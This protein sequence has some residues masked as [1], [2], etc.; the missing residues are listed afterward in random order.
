[1]H[2]SAELT[3]FCTVAKFMFLESVWKNNNKLEY[4]ALKPLSDTGKTSIEA[5]GKVVWETIGKNLWLCWVNYTSLGPTPFFYIYSR[6]CQQLS[7]F[8]HLTTWRPDLGISNC[9]KA[10][11]T[12]SE[13]IRIPCDLLHS[14][15][16]V[17][18]QWVYG[19]TDSEILIRTVLCCT[20]FDEDCQ[21][22]MS[23][24]WAQ[25]RNNRGF[26][27]YLF[28]LFIFQVAIFHAI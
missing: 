14:T 21:I 2:T 23:V 9:T 11:Q 20:F 10:R 5:Y 19:Q 12:N 15:S 25:T 4:S 16:N 28:Y 26:P 1:M 27:I 22:N 7:G 13:V 6:N 17:C 18:L 8:T 3:C 24:F